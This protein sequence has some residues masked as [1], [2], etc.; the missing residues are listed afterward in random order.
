MD[1]R[2]A[3]GELVR[4][5]RVYVRN[6]VTDFKY[7]PGGQSYSSSQHYVQRTEWHFID[8][9]KFVETVVKKLPTYAET[10]RL[11][12]SRYSTTAPQAQFWLDRFVQRLVSKSLENPHDGLAV[13]LITMLIRDL[14]KSPVD[15]SVTAYLNHAWLEKESFELGHHTTLRRPR[16]T[17]FEYEQPLDSM[18][19]LPSRLDL[20]PSAILEA[21]IH[22]REGTE[23]QGELDAIVDTLRLF[24]LGAIGVLK[25]QLRPLSLLSPGATVGPGP[26]AMGTNDCTFRKGDAERLAGFFPRVKPLVSA[27]ANRTEEVSLQRF[28]D[29]LLSPLPAEVR[30]STGITALE[31]LLLRERTELAHR[32]SLRVA[33][34]LGAAAGL[35]SP[36]VYNNV[37]RAYELRSKVV[38]GSPLSP[39]D[40][41]SASASSDAILE[42]CRLSLVIVLGLKERI[43]SEQLLTR[44]DQ[45]LLDGGARSALSADLEVVRDLV[46]QP[47]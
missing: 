20:L 21:S 9:Y 4:T 3:A 25:C 36:E 33:A 18:L 23:A 45:S 29:A 2:K 43:S 31:S 8:Q 30:V 34:L 39:K 7:Q 47:G 6:E 10:V 11:L 12:S 14:D 13:D 5:N 17:D 24:R 1:A 44:L 15:W 46:G 38:H 35:S 32:L 27:K 42:Y 26:S 19:S 16:P 40:K 41:A 28:K 37:R 22:A